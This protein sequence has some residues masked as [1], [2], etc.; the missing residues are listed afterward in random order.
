MMDEMRAEAA[1]QFGQA[2]DLLVDACRQLE[3][4][5]LDDPPVERL[6]QA[7]EEVTQRVHRMQPPEARLQREPADLAVPGCHLVDD[8]KAGETK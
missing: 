4:Y 7:L 6:Y 2:A 8:E 3:Q 1:R 5:G